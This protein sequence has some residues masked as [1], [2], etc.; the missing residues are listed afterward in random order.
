MYSRAA[1][2]LIKHGQR[3]QA[4]DLLERGTLALSAAELW[5]DRA[6]VL[7]L[8]ERYDEALKVPGAD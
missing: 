8:V 6:L 7:A 2:F 4:A 5:I 1:E 3:E